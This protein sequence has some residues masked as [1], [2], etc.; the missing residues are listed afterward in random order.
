MDEGTKFY[1]QSIIEMLREIKNP[2]SIMMIFGFVRGAYKEE[3]E[4]I[5]NNEQSRQDIP[6]TY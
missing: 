1:K 6:G 4:G 5:G 2:K 3:K